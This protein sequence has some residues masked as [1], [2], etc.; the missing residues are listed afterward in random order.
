[1]DLQQIL[2][3]A[4]GVFGMVL[5][6]VISWLLAKKKYYT[7]VD[8]GIIENMQKSLDFYKL[9]SD[10][11]QERLNEVIK[12]NDVLEEGMRELRKQMFEIV[13]NICYNMTCQH[14]QLTA[15]TDGIKSRKKVEKE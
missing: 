10:D 6:S 1:M 9:L 7:E 14:R 8:N 5:S 11:T 2:T 12:R 4:G 3:W 15:D 13:V